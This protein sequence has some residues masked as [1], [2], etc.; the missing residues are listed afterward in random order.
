MV[1]YR[2][3]RLR[4]LASRP[5]RSRFTQKVPSNDYEDSLGWRPFLSATFCQHRCCWVW[6]CKNEPLFEALISRRGAAQN[7]H[8]NG[9]WSRSPVLGAA[10]APWAGAPGRANAGPKARASCYRRSR[11]ACAASRRRW[12]FRPRGTD[13][14]RTTARLGWIPA[15]HQVRTGPMARG[16]VQLASI[17]CSANE[18][19]VTMGSMAW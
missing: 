2:P 3:S 13:E 7:L 8:W 19:A 11:L 17:R 5:P 9:S 16:T 18:F 12:R 1:S 15:R 6:E 14:G 10:G 4:W